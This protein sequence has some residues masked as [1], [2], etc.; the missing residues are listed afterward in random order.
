MS[1]FS[2]QFYGQQDDV[3]M[4]QAENAEKYVENLLHEGTK[5]ALRVEKLI[6][7]SWYDDEKFKR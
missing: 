7:P 3:K 6:P 4:A 5:I 2:D 1:A